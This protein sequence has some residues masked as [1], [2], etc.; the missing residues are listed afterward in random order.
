[1]ADPSPATVKLTAETTAHFRVFAINDAG[2]STENSN[3]DSAT[4]SKANR[5][6]P[7]MNLIAVQFEEESPSGGVNLYWHE[8]A[9]DGGRAIASYE[10]EHKRGSAKWVSTEVTVEVGTFPLGA[11]VAHDYRHAPTGGEALEQ[12]ERVQYRVKAKH[13][14]GTSRVSNTAS[15]T[16]IDTTGDDGDDPVQPDAP[17]LLVPTDLDDDL[18]G[19]SG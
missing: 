4:T 2:T 17:T 5:P 16:M 14:D 10:I 6:D 8:P 1:M 18:P 12:G 19:K 7:P 11:T 15:I 3:V 9:D 13:A